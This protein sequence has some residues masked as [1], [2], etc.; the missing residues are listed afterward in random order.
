MKDNKDYLYYLWQDNE[1]EWHQEFAYL[2][3]E[4]SLKGIT[5]GG[6]SDSN[7]LICL[8]SF[9]L[10]ELMCAQ[11]I[12]KCYFQS[13]SGHYYKFNEAYTS[14]GLK[15][16]VEEIL[17]EI[18]DGRVNYISNGTI[19]LAMY[20]CGYKFQ[21]IPGTPNCLFNVPNKCYMRMEDKLR[22]H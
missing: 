2:E 3:K 9:N 22:K 20:H 11:D 19:I 21:R 6:F 8:N 4:K 12:I 18:T 5:Y 13:P 1:V 7:K 14:Y 16:M 10:E 15:H 17:Y